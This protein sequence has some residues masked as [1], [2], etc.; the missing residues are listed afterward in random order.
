MSHPLPSPI[1]PLEISNEKA[2]SLFCFLPCHR[3][4]SAEMSSHFLNDNPTTQCGP[5][6][7]NSRPPLQLFLIKNPYLRNKNKQTT[8]N[9]AM[10]IQSQNRNGSIKTM[11][12]KAT[13]TKKKRMAHSR[14]VIGGSL[15]FDHQKHC[16]LCVIY[17]TK[18]KEAAKKYKKG[19]HPKCPHRTKP[20]TNQSNKID[21]YVPSSTA[22]MLAAVSA[23]NKQEH[24]L[25]NTSTFLNVAAMP[26]T[27]QRMIPLGNI[28]TLKQDSTQQSVGNDCM[29]EVPLDFVSELRNELDNRMKEFESG[30]K[31]QWAKK[32]RAPIVFSLAIDYITS[33]FAHRRTKAT[34]GTLPMT[35]TFEVAMD[36][37]YELFPQRT[38]CFKFPVDLSNS[39][40][41]HYHQLQ[42]CSFIYLDWQ[43]CWPQL[44][45]PCPCCADKVARGATPHSDSKL[46]HDRTNLLK[47]RSLFPIWTPSG[48]VIYAVVMTYKCQK[49]NKHVK[50]NDGRLLHL[51][52]AHVRDT[53]P[54]LPRYAHG[55]FH[56][57]TELS[58]IIDSVMKTYGNAEFVSRQMV[59]QQ[60]RFYQRKV[61]SYL[62]MD[63]LHPYPDYETWRQDIHPPMPET[64][65]NT[66]FEAEYSSLQPYG[67]CN[68]ERY[69]RELQGVQVQQS[70]I[71]MF[72][73]TFQVLKTYSNKGGAKAVF[74]GM[75]GSTKEVVSLAAVP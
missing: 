20:P 46:V 44:V 51:L 32:T 55:Q 58:D 30:N 66:Y 36:R 64:I 14:M 70:D 17:N 33:L 49:C 53:Y 50:A 65:R 41:P 72:D 61:L 34:D 38:C 13:Q 15:Q 26:A 40:S 12:K 57:N 10:G 4:P 52:D 47:N 27:V 5:S 21:R 19:H 48:S 24:S 9:T 43:L 16:R 60:G 56:F 45:L 74:T 71:V 67:Y 69:V 75:K 11:K 22:A 18:G 3:I 59:A 68:V 6:T 35:N 29:D 31:F 28:A 1:R 73:H 37:Y 54:V 62:S 63:V 2:S 7:A 42:G 25:E 23:Q 39:P 8:T